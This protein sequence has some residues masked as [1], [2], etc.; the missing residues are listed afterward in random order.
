MILKEKVITQLKRGVEYL[1][2]FIISLSK[3]QW[4]PSQFTIRGDQCPLFTM[5]G[6]SCSIRKF[7]FA[8]GSSCSN[9][10]FNIPW[11]DCI[12]WREVPSLVDDFFC[13]YLNLKLL[14]V[15][16]PCLLE[17][18]FLSFRNRHY[19]RAQDL[20]TLATLLFLWSDMCELYIYT[21]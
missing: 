16:H 21:R 3:L 14:R 1:V 19:L 8:C 20:G 4:A 9:D 5:S 18:F 17:W 15:S 12:M 11:E 10:C 13:L 6:I 2:V 7:L